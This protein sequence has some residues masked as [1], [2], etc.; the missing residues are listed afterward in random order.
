MIDEK[1]IR[2]SNWLLGLIISKPA[3]VKQILEG[4]YP[5]RI[6]KSYHR[7]GSGLD[8]LLTTPQN[9][10]TDFYTSKYNR[11]GGMMGDFIECLPPGLTLT[12]AEEKFQEAYEKSGYKLPL[13]RILSWLFT[14]EENYLFYQDS[15]KHEGKIILD[16]DEYQVIQSCLDR[17]KK[18]RFARKY[19]WPEK[20]SQ[21]ILF[22][23]RIKFYFEG[24]LVKG[25]LDGII[26]DH[27]NETLTPFDLKTTAHSALKFP[28]T[29]LRSYYFRQA[30]LYTLGLDLLKGEESRHE[31]NDPKLLEYLKKYKLEPFRF[32]VV[33]KDFKLP[34]PAIVYKCSDN[35]IHSGIY[36]GN[37]QGSY[38]KGIVQLIDDFRWH[39]TNDLWEMPREIYE[40]KGE[41]N[42]DI[43]DPNQKQ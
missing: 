1:E 40:N 27:E 42:L 37:H 3:E 12:S 19:F 29:F 7:I 30:A 18:S 11:P 17:I 15:K 10:E 32:V 34:E 5:D 35:D 8:C 25:I 22:Q 43:F 26:V 39:L 9:W 31:D 36:G 21:E 16:K 24:F 4:N 38:Y 23:V 41:G 13:R 14:R 6:E 20:D 2:I 28:D 33:S